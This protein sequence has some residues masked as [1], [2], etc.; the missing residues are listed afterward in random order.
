MIHS[1]CRKEWA[2][3]TEESRLSVVGRKPKR[4]RTA[5][6][7]ERNPGGWL[8]F[9]KERPRRRVDSQPISLRISVDFASLRYLSLLRVEPE[10]HDF[11]GFGRDGLAGL[12]GGRIFILL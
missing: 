2:E 1:W 7:P 11:G 10:F 5:G 3:R 6:S 12:G 8:F 9:V 4:L